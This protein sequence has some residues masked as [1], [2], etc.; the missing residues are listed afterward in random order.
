VLSIDFTLTSSVRFSYKF[1]IKSGKLLVSGDMLRIYKNR[2]I[3]V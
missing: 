2:E 3:L 1:F